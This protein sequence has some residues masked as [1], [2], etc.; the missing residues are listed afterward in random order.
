[1]PSAETFWPPCRLPRCRRPFRSARRLKW[2]LWCFLAAALTACGQQPVSPGLT[3]IPASLDRPC[4]PGPA[5][6][7]G[8]VTVAELLE[9]MAQR[10]AAARECRARVEGLRAGWP[11]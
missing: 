2:A 7:A 10:E 8:D 6:P 11:R 1:M 9:I 3:P 5:L 4:F